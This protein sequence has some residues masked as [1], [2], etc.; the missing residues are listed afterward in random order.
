MKFPDTS[1]T[2]SVNIKQWAKFVHITKGTRNYNVHS[3][4]SQ[5][6]LAV[7]GTRFDVIFIKVTEK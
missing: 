3:L 2:S 4:M 7:F 1:R 6:V 5:F